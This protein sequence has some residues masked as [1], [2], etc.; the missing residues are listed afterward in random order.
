MR[1]FAVMF[2]IACVLAAG[3]LTSGCASAPAANDTGAAYGLDPSQ[4]QP[5][6][7]PVK[8]S[9]PRLEFA[10]LVDL[11]RRDEISPGTRLAPEDYTV[12]STGSGVTSVQWVLAVEQ[13]STQLWMTLDDESASEV[14]SW[15]MA[16]VG[17]PMLL[18]ADGEVVM[19]ATVV[20]PIT[21]GSLAADMEAGQNTR[22]RLEALVVRGE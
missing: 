12:F 17:E 10:G 8:A 3:A 6:S 2:A 22:E 14:E 1:R 21:G 18:I 15:T 20:E 5:E 19:S 7:E 11:T 9:M 13:Q 4:F 16:H